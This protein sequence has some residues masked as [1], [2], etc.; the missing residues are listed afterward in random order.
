MADNPIKYSDFVKPDDSVDSLTSK[1]TEL[2]TTFKTTKEEVVKSA[3]ELEKALKLVGSATEEDKVK[4]AEY[5]AQAKKLIALQEKLT[6]AE[7]DNAKAIAATELELK[8][9]TALTK[10]MAKAESNLSKEHLENTEKLNQLK[11][12]QQQY[13]KEQ[14]LSA[15]VNNSAEGSYKQLTAQYALNVRALDAMGQKEREATEEGKLLSKQTAELKAQMVSLKEKQGTYNLSVGNYKKSWDGLGNSVNQV[16]REMPA[17]AVSMNTFFLAISNNL[18]MLVDEINNI[19]NANEAVIKQNADVRA[20]VASAGTEI[21]KTTSIWKSLGSAIFSWNMAI[22]LAI[23]G[24][25]LFGGKIIKLIASLSAGNGGLKLFIETQKQLYEAS[26]KASKSAAKETTRLDILYGAVSDLNRTQK[27]RLSAIEE[28]RKKY[29][30][31]FKN[32]TDEEML[33]GKA[34]IA[35]QKLRNSIIATA[36][37]RAYEAKIFDNTKKIVE[38]EIKITKAKD[39]QVKLDGFKSKQLAKNKKDQAELIAKQEKL[40]GLI[41]EAEKAGDIK[42]QALLVVDQK[43]LAS[44]QS[45]LVK[46]QLA[47]NKTKSTQGGLVDYSAV[48]R[49]ARVAELNREIADSKKEI[50]TLDNINLK[51]QENINIDDLVFDQKDLDSA[52]KKKNAALKKNNKEAVKMRSEELR[53]VSD[54]AKSEID[55]I[56]DKYEKQRAELN[57]SASQERAELVQIQEENKT[58]T[59]AGQDAIR[60]LIVNNKKKLNAELENLNNEQSIAEIEATQSAI[61]IKMGI[62]EDSGT[63]TVESKVALLNQLRSLEL[64]KNDIVS[65]G[66][67]T[68]ADINNEYDSEILRMK[69]TSNKAIYDER[70]DFINLQNQLLNSGIEI[71]KKTEEE[72]TRMKLQA[73]KERI[74]A[75]LALNKTGLRQL[76]DQEIEILENNKKNI[77]NELSSKGEGTKD[78]YDLVGLNLD[79]DEK[80]AIITST[81]FAIGQLND[82]LAAKVDIANQAVEAADKGVD[83]A[84]SEVDAQK[85]ARNAGYAS[86]VSGAQKELDLAK[87]TQKKAL[88]QQEKAVKTQQRLETI[89]QAT[90]LITASA[91]IWGTLGFPFAIPALAVMWG[92]FAASKIKANQATKTKQFGDGG[93][94]FLNGGSHAS[95][96][97][98]PLYKSNGVERR[99]EGGEAMAIVNK[100]STNKYRQE[101]PGIV[102]A[103]NKGVFAETYMNSYR[104]NDDKVNVSLHSDNWNGSRMEGDISAMR[105]YNENS[106]NIY[107]DGKGRVVEIYKNRKRIY[108][109]N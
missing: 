72:K 4:S 85:E 6:L 91:K 9:R 1:L 52:N 62:D 78:I 87:E 43:K 39:E 105:S 2:A 109:A 93:L 14:K 100:R 34:N 96:N 71:E 24:L 12:E 40:T 38:L 25:T 89:Q 82:F 33:V 108:N 51:I 8:A 80:E 11:I 15:Q 30:D 53:L 83:A 10:E 90:S 77:D 60:T 13:N 20:G 18:P 75:I 98:I 79:D 76:N 48:K 26:E 99:A 106:K 31:T 58:L 73:E 44:K 61:E 84:Q 23:T 70:V 28:L 55:L 88:A 46:E 21:Q 3:K 29:P 37:A 101:L 103:L 17:M 45:D 41:K 63:Q 94:E 59:A 36:K 104:P 27:E 67:R 102:E 47:L 97:D 95:G 42:K 57:F 35:Y 49:T 16:A 64:L 54:A 56:A 107:V 92:S 5:A 81:Q 68:E 74:E 69:N 32:L 86:D 7:N 65:E 22:T 50:N 66:A 19:K